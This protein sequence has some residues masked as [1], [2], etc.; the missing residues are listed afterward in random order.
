MQWTEI[1]RA[2]PDQWLVVEALEAHTIP[3]QQ[4][5][6]DRLAVIE[7]CSD[8]SRAMATY[9]RY[10]KQHPMR[11][12]YFIHTSRPVL[13]IRERQWLGIRRGDVHT[14]TG[15]SV[16]VHGSELVNCCWSAKSDL[17]GNPLVTRLNRYNPRQ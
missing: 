9:R 16:R 14:I 12:F 4:R 5:Q 1:R 7:L 10:H 17:S 8:G 3:D 11:E 2:Y 15:S 6:F 13:D